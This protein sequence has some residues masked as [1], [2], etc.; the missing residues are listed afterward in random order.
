MVSP[1]L[2]IIFFIFN[3]TRS[4]DFCLWI[5]TLKNKSRF[6]IHIKSYGSATLVKAV[7]WGS[8]TIFLTVNSIMKIKNNAY[9]EGQPFLEQQTS[10]SGRDAGSIQSF[11]NKGTICIKIV[12][13]F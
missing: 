10:R 7:E 1:R 6:R 11:Y 4:Y 12:L 5:L 13:V 8:L 9:P 3:L 2:T